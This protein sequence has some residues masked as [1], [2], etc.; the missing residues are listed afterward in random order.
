MEPGK[1]GGVICQDLCNVATWLFWVLS[2]EEDGE[3][4]TDN[5]GNELQNVDVKATR[6]FLTEG[7][8]FIICG[9]HVEAHTHWILS[10]HPPHKLECRLHPLMPV[11]VAS[12]RNSEVIAHWINKVMG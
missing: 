7:F 11:C 2:H 5:D 6:V 8:A 9:S 3:P 1:G 10:C 4:D 12:E